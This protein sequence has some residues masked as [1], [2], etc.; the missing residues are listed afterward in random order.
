TLKGTIQSWFQR[1]LEKGRQNVADPGGGASTAGSRPSL[2]QW[3]KGSLLE[4]Q[5]AS[6]VQRLDPVKE[7]E[8]I[9]S[10]LQILDTGTAEEQAWAR[11][12][13]EA[14]ASSF[15]E[16]ARNQAAY[17][18]Y[19]IYNN[20]LY[21]GYAHRSAQQQRERLAKLGVAEEWYKSGV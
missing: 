16:I 15:K 21:M 14:I 4:L 17:K 12:E 8:R 20:E 11:K 6:L 5:D 10:L 7:D 18:I 19:V 9:A 13:L 3:I 2:L 1:F